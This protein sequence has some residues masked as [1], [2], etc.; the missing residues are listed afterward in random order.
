MNIKT[1]VTSL[2]TAVLAVSMWLPISVQ[3][4]VVINRW[5]PVE[6]VIPGSPLCGNEHV[7]YLLEGMIH[8]KLATLRNGMFALNQHSLGTMTPLVSE[9][10]E[11]VFSHTIHEVYPMTGENEVYSFVDTLKVIG[12]GRAPNLHVKIRNHVTAIDGEIKSFFDI[13]DVSCQE[14]HVF[15]QMRRLQAPPMGW[16]RL[17]SR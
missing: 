9:E 4:E 14:K 8:T 17:E 3:A 13:T 10:A 5:D 6:A 11:L 12:K 16:I 15:S 1:C 7:F 2:A